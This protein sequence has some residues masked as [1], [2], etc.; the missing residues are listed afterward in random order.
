MLSGYI[1]QYRR[2]FSKKNILLSNFT[3]PARAADKQVRGGKRGG[4]GRKIHF[5]ILKSNKGLQPGKRGS[6][7][8]LA[9]SGNRCGS[10]DRTTCTAS[11]SLSGPAIPATSSSPRIR[12]GRG[13]GGDS[14]NETGGRGGLEGNPPGRASAYLARDCIVS[15]QGVESPLDVL[16][17]EH[18]ED[19][20]EQVGRLRDGLVPRL[21][22]LGE[23]KQ[24]FRDLRGDEETR[25]AAPWCVGNGRI[26]AR[27]HTHAPQSP[28]LR[29]PAGYWWRP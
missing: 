1:R 29:G 12:P 21:V 26:R 13:G 6:F 14:G 7:A 2:S 25:L 22:Q 17:A 16:M 5:G 9:Q 15:L 8:H 18:A 10:A 27:A 28:A 11:F 3:E 23:V 19:A 20:H 4:G 24:V